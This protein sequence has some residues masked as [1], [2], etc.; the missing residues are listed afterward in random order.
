MYDQEKLL[1]ILKDAEYRSLDA[2][3]KCFPP[4]NSIYLKISEKMRVK[5]S[6]KSETYIYHT[7]Y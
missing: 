6:Y 2:N 7:K 3:G 1:E 4:L 5:F